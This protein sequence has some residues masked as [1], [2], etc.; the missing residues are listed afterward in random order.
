MKNFLNKFAVLI[1]YIKL[2]YLYIT[3]LSDFVHYD[4]GSKFICFLELLI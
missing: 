4:V 2:A 1:T 3:L